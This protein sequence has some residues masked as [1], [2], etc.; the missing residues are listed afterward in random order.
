MGG[1]GWSNAYTRDTQVERALDGS[2]QQLEDLVSQTARRDDIVKVSQML[3][4]MLMV[5][6]MVTAHL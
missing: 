6:V 4:L 3:V 1:G 5:M 2:L